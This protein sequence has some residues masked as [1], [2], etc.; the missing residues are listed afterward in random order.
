MKSPSKKNGQQDGATYWCVQ[1]PVL[2]L[3]ALW[4]GPVGPCRTWAVRVVM[5]SVVSLSTPPCHRW[6]GCMVVDPRCVV[7]GLFALLSSPPCRPWA[8][9]LV[10]EPAVR[11]WAARRVVEPAVSSLGSSRCC[12]PRRVIVD[13]RCV[14]LGPLAS[15]STLPCR[16]WAVRLV[17]EPAVSSL[18]RLCCRVPR[19]VVLG[20][21]AWWW[22]PRPWAVRVRVVDPAVS[23]LGCSR[24]CRP[25]RRR[26]PRCVVL[27]PFAPLSSPP[28]H[29]WAARLVVEPA[30]RPWAARR[31][32]EPAV[33]SM[34]CSP[35]C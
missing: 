24:R 21:V 20:P 5:D 32:V 29:P 22:T 1:S 30:V 26:G 10:V 27:G 25:C 14:V 6:A 18:G 31:V 11:P 8:A 2:L 12:R 3:V 15:S 17:V 16:P 19:R 7:L 9:R 23:S 34:G 4:S 13:P 28:C 33:S 35:R